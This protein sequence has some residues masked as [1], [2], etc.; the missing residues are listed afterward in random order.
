[1]PINNFTT[2]RDIT[3]TFVTPQVGALSLNLI[4]G[5]HAKQA[6]DT[7][8]PKGIDSLIRHVRFFQGWGGGF[9]IERRDSTLD[10]YFALLEQQYWQG[11]SEQAAFMNVTIAEAAGNL[12][13]WQFT[14]V[15]ASY[16]DA[17]EYKGDS[18]VKQTMSFLASQRIK[19]A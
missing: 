16:D 12:T 9:S 2:G 14:N 1:M 17:G 3:I 8:S 6:S 15:L 5:W 18:T 13:Q 7:Q 19:I 4:T 11:I 10:D